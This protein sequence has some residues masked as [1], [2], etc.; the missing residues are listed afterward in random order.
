MSINNT[1]IYKYANRKATIGKMGREWNVLLYTCIYKKLTDQ[2][3]AHDMSAALRF[4]L[5]KQS[6]PT[7]HRPDG[8]IIFNI[9]QS[10]DNTIFCTAMFI[11][12]IND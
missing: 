10:K 12:L 4:P 3:C 7:T 1:Y 11:S 5:G 9:N 8:D 6:F 2:V